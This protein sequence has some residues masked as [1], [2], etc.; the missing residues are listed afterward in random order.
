MKKKN[1]KKELGKARKFKNS[2]PGQ[3]RDFETLDAN[4]MFKA[5]ESIDEI[6][7]AKDRSATDAAIADWERAGGKI[8]K[9]KF[10]GRLKG[11]P[12]RRR[13]IIKSRKEETDWQSMSDQQ[14]KAKA[15]AHFPP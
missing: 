10:G 15:K 1:I 14:K 7:S 2:T 11:M 8:K 13:A 9:L 6:H 12:K 3:N 4:R 5:Y